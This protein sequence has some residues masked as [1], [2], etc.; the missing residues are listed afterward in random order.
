VIGS[1]NDFASVA[2]ASIAGVVYLDANDDGTRQTTELGLGGV[3]VTMTGTDDRGVAVSTTATSAT[4]GLYAFANLRPGTYAVTEAPPSAD[5]DG[6]VTAGSSGGTVGAHRVVGIALVPGAVASSYDFGHVAPTSI[7]GFVFDDLNDNGTRETG[8][9][10]LAGVSVTLTGTDDIGSAV[11]LTTSTDSGGY[12]GFGALRPGTYTLASATPTGYF[13]GKATG[14]GAVASAPGVLSAM[15]LNPGDSFRDEDFGQVRPVSLAGSVYIDHNGDGVR[16]SSEVG[17]AGASVTLGGVDDLGNPVSQVATTDASGHYAFANLRPGRY[18]LNDGRP[19]V[20][21]SGAASVGSAGGATGPDVVQDILAGDGAS[22][23]G[24]DFALLG[25]SITGRVAV[26][27]DSGAGQ[28]AGL[29]GST[30][31]LEDPTGQ[32]LATTTSGADGFYQ[33]SDLP[34]GAYALALS[35]PGGYANAT[36]AVRSATVPLAG[37]TAQDFG[38]STSSL[39]GVIYVDANNNGVQDP[40]EAGLAGQVVTLIGQDANGQPVSETATTASDGSYRFLGLLSGDY[41]LSETTPSGYLDG[42]QALG[43]QGGTVGA[44]RFSTIRLNAKAAGVGYRFAKL[45]PAVLSGFAYV[46]AHGDALKH[47]DDKGLAGVPVTLAGTDDL[48]RPVSRAL[49][50]AGDGSY[51]FADLRPGLYAVS[52]TTPDVYAQ[53]P[54]DVG[55]VGGLQAKAAITQVPLAPGASATA[56][57]FPAKGSNVSGVVFD[58]PAGQGTPKPGSFGVSGATVRLI[59]SDGQVVAESV[60]GLDGSY[61]FPAI[62]AGSYTISVDRPNPD[63]TTTHI[64]KALSLQPGVAARASFAANSA[65]GVIAGGVFADRFDS[66]TPAAGD[67]GLAGIPVTLTGTDTLGQPVLKATTTDLAGSYAFG[68]LPDGSYTVSAATPAGYLADRASPT[69]QAVTLA[70][71]SSSTANFAK[72]PPSS[73]A[74]VVYLDANGD[75][76]MGP[77]EFGIANVPVTLTGVDDLGRAVSES[78][79][80]DAD[81]RY[82]FSDLRVG[83]Y[84]VAR[85]ASPAFNDGPSNVGTVGGVAGRLRIAQV[86]LVGGGAGQGYDFAQRIKPGCFLT[87]PA[88]QRVVTQGPHPSGPSTTSSRSTGHVPTKLPHL[89]K[90][91]HPKVAH[92]LPRLASRIGVR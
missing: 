30:V 78:T 68:G 82:A 11:S 92:Y 59:G 66:G 81:G 37:L 73:I 22:G 23:V 27:P 50:T 85:G 39:A 34:A 42:R 24:Y 79:T 7:G 53:G 41:S 86:S 77:N 36:P 51:A 40:G 9:L 54:T 43:T 58:D 3:V 1:E 35:T 72:L 19:S 67:Y 69:A 71:G 80:T 74:G 76:K 10:G 57:N 88:V 4:D 48:G 13:T 62:P 8:E 90:V 28:G 14:T 65:V 56:Y 12:Y 18:S 89:A 21:S 45:V 6:A 20:Y 91:S 47:P 15:V 16:Q 87:L 70:N 60:T 2:P 38:L 17:L 25:A 83:T 5:Y 55:T 29:A 44:N 64:V 31:S 75:G 32:V 49:M 46:D 52:G 84:S 61:L 26:L 33:F 63:G